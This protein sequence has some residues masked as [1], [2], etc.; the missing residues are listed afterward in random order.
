MRLRS[1][2]LATLHIENE[3]HAITCPYV[4]GNK[5]LGLTLWDEGGTLMHMLGARAQNG[6]VPTRGAFGGGD[7]NLDR[8]G[9]TERGRGKRR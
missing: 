6:C 4:V 7:E 9:E 3:M 8:G 2:R 1:Q 5:P